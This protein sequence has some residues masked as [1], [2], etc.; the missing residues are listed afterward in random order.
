MYLKVRALSS[1]GRATA[2][3]L[4]ILPIVAFVTT[5]I[6]AP[7]FYLDVAEDPIFIIGS[8]LLLTLYTVG[9]LTIRKMIDL[10]V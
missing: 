8:L 3:M 1:E 5:F 9:V 4:S 2:W 6:A 7:S 10:K